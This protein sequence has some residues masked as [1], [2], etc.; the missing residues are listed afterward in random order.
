V[1]VSVSGA[2]TPALLGT[3]F[4]PVTLTSSG[5]ITVQN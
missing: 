1:T 4:P 3:E 5:S 2:W